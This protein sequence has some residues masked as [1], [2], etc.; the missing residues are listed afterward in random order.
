MH[1]LNRYRENITTKY[2]DYKEPS[3]GKF[4]VINYKEYF[5]FCR[6]IHCPKTSF[7]TETKYV[8]SDRRQENNFVSIEQVQTR[9]LMAPRRAGFKVIYV[10]LFDGFPTNRALVVGSGKV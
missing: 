7:C 5:L 6:Y 3:F 2:R 1:I 9:G 8:N 4:I 10:S